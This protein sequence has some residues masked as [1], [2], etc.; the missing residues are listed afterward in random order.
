MLQEKFPAFTIAAAPLQVTADRPER[1][2]DAAPVT[3]KVGLVTLAPLEGEEIAIEGGVLSTLMVA[4]ACA[5]L[6]A[7]SV[8]EPETTW[9]APS[10]ATVIGGGQLAMP[11][12]V[13][14]HV[15]LT[16]TSVLFQPA[17]LGAGFTDA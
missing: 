15:K 3:T 14:A 7:R 9:P 4:V 10:E 1:L 2:S 8:A 16:V 6:P 5:V 17:V 12:R 11:E 13:S